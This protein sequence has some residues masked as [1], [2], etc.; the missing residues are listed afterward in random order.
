VQTNATFDVVEPVI[1]DGSPVY[2]EGMPAISDAG[3]VVVFAGAG[4]PHS[5]D[6]WKSTRADDG[7]WGER[8]LLTASSPQP[9]NN[10]PSLSR[11]GT[12]IF[13]NCGAERDPESGDTSACVV[14]LEDDSG[15]VDVVVAPD[16]LPDGR[17]SFVNFPRDAGGGVVVFEASWPQ[18]DG[19]P[20]E[21]LWQRRGDEA[22]TPAIGRD[23][24]NTVSPCVLADGSI[25]A[26]W[27]GRPGGTGVH[28][29][30]HLRADGTFTPLSPDG[31]D[32][33]DIGIGCTN[34]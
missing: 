4:G 23:F 10:Q 16:T 22:P 18:D 9:F 33:D 3:D 30:T 20:P 11:D 21:T 25:V 27:L 29:L 13:F 15:A 26:L 14:D 8:V 6:L 34:R 32:V 5:L 28:E 17:N 31:V 12:R 7:A 1:I 24:D 2:L 19:E